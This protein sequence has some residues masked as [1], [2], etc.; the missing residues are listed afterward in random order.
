MPFIA[1]GQFNQPK[2]I[3]VSLGEDEK[4][5][6]VVSAEED[7]IFL[8]REVKNTETKR[9]RKWQVP[10]LDTALNVVWNND[11]YVD[12]RY[13]VRGYGYYGGYFYLL[14]EEPGNYGKEMI[15]MRINALDR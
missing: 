3:E 2:R 12:L 7:G 4:Y 9:D 10:Y 15:V 8:Y 5:F 13:M 1:W 11:Y 6:N 14:Y